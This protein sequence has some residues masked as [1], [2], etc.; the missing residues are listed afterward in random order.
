MYAYA[1]IYQRTNECQFMNDQWRMRVEMF[2]SHLFK[3]DSASLIQF[4]PKFD[5]QS[6]IHWFMQRKTG[7]I[8]HSE[9]KQICLCDVLCIDDDTVE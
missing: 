8:F 2:L 7:S 1:A 5:F 3:L 4:Q 9:Y 6:E